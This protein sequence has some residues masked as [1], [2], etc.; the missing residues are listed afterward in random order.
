MP[1]QILTPTTAGIHPEKFSDHLYFARNQI[2]AVIIL[3]VFLLIGFTLRIHDLGV[4][5]L[6]E[7]E[8]NKLQTVEEYRTNGLSGKNGE[9]PFLMKGLQTISIASA[10]KLNNSIASPHLHIPEEAALRFPVALFGT[11]TALLLFLFVSELFGRSIG[12]TTAALWSVEPMA[13]GFDRI[14]K[15]DSLVLFFFLVT[16][17]FFVKS[18]TKAEQGH[19]NWIRYVWG[20]AAGF[21]ALMA[22][23]YYP[24]FLSIIGGYYNTFLRLPNKKWDIGNLRWI[25]FFAIMG[26]VFLL[27]N[28]TILLP[29]TWHEMLKFSSEKRIGHDSYEFIGVLYPHKVTDWLNGVPWTFYYVFIAVKTSLTTL[30]LFFIGL[31]LMFKRNLGDGRFYLLMWAFLWFMPFTFLGGKFTRYFTFA[32][33][34]ILISA[35]VGFYFGVNWLSG[36]LSITSAAVCQIILFAALLA[37]PLFASLSVTPHFRLFTNPLG[38]GMAAAGSYFPHDEFYDT[39]THD[40]VTAIAPLAESGAI[41]AC[42]TPTLFEYY[43]GKINRRDLHFVSL[44]EKSEV[45]ALRNGDFIVLTKGRRYFSNTAYEDYLE[46][47]TASSADIKAGG[48]M[49]ARIYQLNENSLAVVKAIANQ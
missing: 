29:D 16:S 7:D 33:P 37:G 26:V 20:S 19:P 42:E 40:V 30:A 25:L 28:P 47:Q 22:S 35:A 44:S 45:A 38:G 23:K 1:V 24:F 36:K 21:G 31:P 3:C 27:L 10:E 8:F 17:L 11:F 43:A 14:A 49:S 13:I 32:E 48:V 15:E 18:Q 2:T 46:K 12:L 9:H 6:S 4:E 5:S 39:S 34:L 41:I